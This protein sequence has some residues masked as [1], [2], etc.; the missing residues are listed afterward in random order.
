LA[1]LGDESGT[2]GVDLGGI[3]VI[4]DASLDLALDHLGSVIRTR[5]GLTAPERIF[6][7]AG[8][9]GNAEGALLLPGGS[10][11][12]KT[13]LVAA[14]IH[15]GATYY[16]DEYAVL[17]Y[18]G[19]VHRYATPLSPGDGDQIQQNHQD[20]EAVGDSAPDQALPIYA[21]IV[22]TYRP[23]AEWAPKRLSKAD[24]AVA[25]L[26]S[27]ITAMYRPAEA[28]RVISGAIEGA[29]LLAGDR[30]EADQVAPLLLAELEARTA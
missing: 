23:G 16:S 18:D 2:Y 17:D 24:G 13:T 14:L 12:G 29:I 19:L 3:S 15:A 1:I 30:G 26:G 28:M 6:I 21:V 20:L 8:V 27:T 11:S 25:V 7:R 9:V 4:R 5:I 22:T 10:F